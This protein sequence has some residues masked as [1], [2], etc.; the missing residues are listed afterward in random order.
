MKK[1]ITLVLTVAL[2]VAC[3]AG[4]GKEEKQKLVMGT[5]AGFP[6][7]EYIGD[8]GNVT[9]IDA[10]IAK[11]VADKLGMELEIKDQEFKGLLV[12]VENGS[13]D[14]V[15][16]GLTVNEE[17]KQQVNFT[18]SYAKGVQVIIVKEGSDITSKE[19]I[20]ALGKTVGVQ[21]GTTG[22][23]YCTGDFGQD[24]VKQYTYGALAVQALLND[25]VDCVVLDK[26]PAKT[27]VKANAGLTI[28]ETAYTEEDY[29]AAVSK[30]NTELLEKVDKALTEL[31]ADGTIQAIIDKYIKAE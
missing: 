29:A 13:I 1:I 11:A 31:K 26:E 19:D 8:D 23:S 4:C 5:A 21:T 3:F 7:Y 24:Y 28:L 25:Q 10:E 20:K 15:F 22:D 16:A 27:F 9:G 18:Q 12:A 6:P 17:R 30:E 14:I 2:A